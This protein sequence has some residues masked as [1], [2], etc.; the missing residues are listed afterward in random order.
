LCCVDDETHRKAGFSDFEL[1]CFDAKP[2]K[3]ELKMLL[4]MPLE[5]LMLLC[6]RT[7]HSKTR[8]DEFVQE[9]KECRAVNAENKNVAGKRMITHEWLNTEHSCLMLIGLNALK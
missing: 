3:R 9:C 4:S 2:P 1:N 6:L 8:N 5:G 7:L